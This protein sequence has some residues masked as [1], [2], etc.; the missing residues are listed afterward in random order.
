[1]R[2]LAAAAA[3][4]PRPRDVL[5]PGPAAPLD[6]PRGS[7]SRGSRRTRGAGRARPDRPPADDGDPA[8][9][10]DRPARQAA[11]RRDRRGQELD[12]PVELAFSEPM[13]PTSVAASLDV[14]PRPRVRLTWD[15]T[16][17]RVTV[18]PRHAGSPA[19][20]TRS[21]SAGALGASGR[22]MA[23][24]ARAAFLTRAATTGR[25]AA[26]ALSGDVAAVEHRVHAQFD[27]PVAI[28][29]VRRRW[30]SS[31]AVR[32]ALDVGRRRRP[33]PRP[34]SSPRP[35]SSRRDA[36]LGRAGRRCSTRS[37]APVAATPAFTVTT[38]SAPRR[39]PLP[40]DAQRPQR[41]ARLGPL[42]PVHGSRWT[43]GAR[44]A[45]FSVTANG[46]PVA[47]TVRSPR[48]TRSSSSTRPRRCRTGPSSRC[49]SR[50]PP[51]RRPARRSRPASSAASAVQEQPKVATPARAKTTSSTIPRGSS[52]GGSVGGGSWGAVETL[53]PAADELHP[54]RRLGHLD[55]AAAAARAAA[56]SPP[57]WLD[58]G[59]SRRSRRPYAKRLAVD[60][61]CS[62]FI[63]GNPGDRLRAAGYTSYSWAENLG[64]RS[65]QPVLAR[66]SARTSSSRARGRTTAAT[67]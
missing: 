20:T 12:A 37:G 44:S 56:A 36:V 43:A 19:P 35:R 2:K 41:R 5:P 50:P 57:L 45:A 8:A 54:D 62:H 51:D 31:P 9:P 23:E 7:A 47:G 33:A 3:C 22:P 10:A 53:L 28:G 60:N 4:R 59:I 46:Q 40:A 24:P 39:R 61:Q 65:R 21:R 1:M 34:T 13:D 55:R 58:S 18:N 66:S 17:S 14:Q 48:T 11:F 52:G 38:T 67:T 25:I 26:T 49:S 27:R 42:G 29:A 16:G 15:P 32:G 30:R 63:G 6:R 64:C